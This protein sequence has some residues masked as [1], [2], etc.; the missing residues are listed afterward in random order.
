MISIKPGL[1]HRD[2][3]LDM[4]LAYYFH[5]TVESP[6]NY[7][8]I[9]VTSATLFPPSFIPTALNSLPPF[10]LFGQELI[11]KIFEARVT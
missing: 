2:K 7:V 11:I 1:I 6:F 8:I 5:L 4:P 10:I 3:E 9:L